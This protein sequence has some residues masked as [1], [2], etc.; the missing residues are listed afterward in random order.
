MIS[1]DLKTAAIIFFYSVVAIM[2]VLTGITVLFFCELI[3][4]FKHDRKRK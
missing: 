4:S 2:A 1:P 3:Q